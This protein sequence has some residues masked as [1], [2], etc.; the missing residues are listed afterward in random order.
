M[1][2]LPFMI[3]NIP[4]DLTSGFSIQR[5]SAQSGQEIEGSVARHMEL[6]EKGEAPEVPSGQP[7]T[8]IDLPVNA[9]TSAGGI[10][11]SPRTD[12]VTV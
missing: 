12:Y 9:T 7:P 5:A 10:G 3:M 8:F 6:L 4:D 11:V 2:K 1:T